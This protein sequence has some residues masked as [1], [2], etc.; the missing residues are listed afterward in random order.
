[1]RKIIYLILVGAFGFLASGCATIVHGTSTRISIDS[2]PQGAIVKAGQQTITTPGTLLLKNS[3]PQTLHIS[4]DGYQSSTFYLQQQMSGWVWG[5]I[6]LGGFIGIAIDYGSGG[7]YRLSPANVNVVLNRQ[8]D[9][10]DQIA[11]QAVESPQQELTGS[12]NSPAHA[13]QKMLVTGVFKG[14]SLDF[15][16]EVEITKKLAK[17]LKGSGMFKRVEVVD[18]GDDLNVSDM[19]SLNDRGYAYAVVG[20]LNSSRIGYDSVKIIDLENRKEL[21]RGDV[22][23]N[24]QLISQITKILEK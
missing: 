4:K 19:E 5:N 15:D 13:N 1:M 11:N 20:K 24:E 6:L 10:Q 14:D 3:A 12:I 22:K 18:V 7:A 2:K 16:A 23:S 9:A 21:W 8:Q 17:Q